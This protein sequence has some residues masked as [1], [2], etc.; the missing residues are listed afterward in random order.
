MSE[1]K[2][3][4]T[5]AQHKNEEAVLEIIEKFEPIIKKHSRSL[6]NDEDGESETILSLLEIINA[7]NFHNFKAEV[8][9]A[10]LVKYIST[11]LYHSYIRANKY[12]QN[13]DKCI[14]DEKL[15][16]IPICCASI[17]ENSFDNSIILHETIKNLL[18][19]KEYLCIEHIF[20]YGYS[21]AEVAE[22]LGISRQAVNQCKVRALNKLK[23]IYK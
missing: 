22:N 21:V 3:L 23:N 2:L 11:S 20:R 1:L 4:I 13:E 7:I 5:A 17:H 14:Y 10:V 16:D 18:S 12:K 15:L 8:N 9:D 6:K 19:D